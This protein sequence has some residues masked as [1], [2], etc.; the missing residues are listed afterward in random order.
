[1]VNNAQLPLPGGQRNEQASSGILLGG[2]RRTHAGRGQARLSPGT[3]RTASEP[4]HGE[5]YSSRQEASRKQILGGWKTNFRAASSSPGFGANNEENVENAAETASCED[6]DATGPMEPV[7][8]PAKP[9]SRKETQR[10]QLKFLSAEI[11]TPHR[12]RGKFEA[13]YPW[14]IG[15]VYLQVLYRVAT[16][17]IGT[18]QDTYAGVFSIMGGIHNLT[19]KT[20]LRSHLQK[21]RH[22]Q[23][24]TARKADEPWRG[25]VCLISSTW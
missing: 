16:F 6:E 24:A 7:W 8:E 18:R 15:S 1:M 3:V 2:R 14:R 25:P 23:S 9:G 20:S 22:G 19:Q 4:N 5:R 21:R 17:L 10:R 11:T 12:G 13:T